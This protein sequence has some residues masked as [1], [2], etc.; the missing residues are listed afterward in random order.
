MK[1]PDVSLPYINEYMKQEEAQRLYAYPHELL[2]S[3]KGARRPVRA[4]ISAAL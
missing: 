4:K 2:T 1:R 3:E